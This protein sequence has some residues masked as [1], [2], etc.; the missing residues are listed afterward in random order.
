MFIDGLIRFLEVDDL[1]S[2]IDERMT[3]NKDKNQIFLR[4]LRSGERDQFTVVGTHVIQQ[5]DQREELKKRII[6]T[7]AMAKIRGKFNFEA[8]DI[9]NNDDNKKSFK[10]VNKYYKVLDAVMQNKFFNIITFVKD[11]MF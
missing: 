2:L 10:S 11:G 6:S 5:V 4:L 7:F 8:I 9:S 1:L 3:N